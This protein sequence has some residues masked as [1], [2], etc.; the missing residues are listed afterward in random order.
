M[1]KDSKKSGKIAV[2]MGAEMPYIISVES[3]AH[4]TRET[5]MKTAT[6][7]MLNVICSEVASCDRI[8]RGFTVGSPIYLAAV[9]AKTR[10]MILGNYLAKRNLRTKK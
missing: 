10:L 4:L 5:E 1:Y 7:K 9:D 2:D 6:Q 3:D 8:M